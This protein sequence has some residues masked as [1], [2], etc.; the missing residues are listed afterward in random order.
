[1]GL[2]SRIIEFIE[3][4]RLDKASFERLVGLSNDA[5][6]KMGD[7]TR[8]STIDKIS[9][10][11]PELNTVWLKTGVGEMINNSTGSVHVVGDSN[12]ANS[13]AI[14][15]DVNL[16]A[17]SAVINLKQRIKELEEEVKQLK[18]DKAILQEFVT[19]LQNK[20]K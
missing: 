16:G 18:V 11:F 12:I 13:G 4:K 17:N 1:M 9:N 8:K 2:R 15:G 3:Y 14:R 20:K 6:S 7:N 10:V 5:V 19:M